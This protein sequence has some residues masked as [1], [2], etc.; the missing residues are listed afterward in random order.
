[1]SLVVDDDAVEIEEDGFDHLISM[2]LVQISD[3]IS[4]F[5]YF[6]SVIQIRISTETEI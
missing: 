6:K 1:M 5:S 2:S 3:S 4:D